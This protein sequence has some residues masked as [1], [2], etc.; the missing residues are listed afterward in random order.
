MSYQLLQAT[1]LDLKSSYHK[2][3]F[4]VIYSWIVPVDEDRGWQAVL[5]RVTTAGEPSVVTRPIDVRRSC[6]RKKEE[7]FD[8]EQLNTQAA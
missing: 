4:A 5:H 2:K 6:Y 3:Q 7:R 1:R 8:V